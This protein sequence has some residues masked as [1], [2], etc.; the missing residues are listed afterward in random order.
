MLTI[1]MDAMY[2]VAFYVTCGTLLGLIVA[3]AAESRSPED[4]RIPVRVSLLT[5]CVCVAFGI[6]V[7]SKLST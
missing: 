5:V 3:M 1:E 2:A 7:A 4:W 6:W